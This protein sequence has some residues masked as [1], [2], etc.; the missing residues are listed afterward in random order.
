MDDKLAEKINNQMLRYGREFNDLLNEIQNE[1]ESNEID[2]FQ[3]RIG[4]I[5]E[6]IFMEVLE[7]LY[8]DFPSLEPPGFKGK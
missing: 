8:K 5:I 1:C 4:E 3:L 6:C 2:R 7:P